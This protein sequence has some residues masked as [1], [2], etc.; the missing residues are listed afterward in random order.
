MIRRAFAQTAESVIVSWLPL[1][2]DMGLIGGVLQP[3]YLGARC[4]L[5]SPAAF[6]RRPRLWLEAIERYRATTSG[7][8]NFGYE[9]TADKVGEEER[10]GLDLASWQVAFNGAEPVRP[11]TLERFARAFAPCGFRSSAFY[12]C[13]GLAEATLLVSGGEAAAPPVVRRFSDAGLEAHRAETRAETR[14]EAA[15][16]DRR[17][18]GPA[19]PGR[20]RPA[21][22]GAARRDRRPRQPPP[23]AAGPGGRDLGRRSERRR[24]LLEPRRGDGAHLRSPPG[25]GR[26]GGGR[27]ALPAHRRPRLPRRRRRAVRHRPPQGPDHPARPQRLPAGRRAHRR[28][29][30]PGAAP[31]RR[32][33][34][35]RRR[36][37]RGTA[38]GGLRGRAPLPGRRPGRRR[39]GGRG[40]ARRRLRAA[41]GGGVRRRAAAG[42]RPAQDHQRQGAPRRVPPP[43]PVGGLPRPSR[44]DVDGAAG[45]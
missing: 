12:P 9:L 42:R 30:P 17:R 2:H 28:G 16:R 40:G 24:R 23:A 34:L 41:R 43:L 36:R 20:L 6:L 32:G 38:G 31:R 8:P 35:R 22:D 14:T 18:R 45:R 7:G 3:L 25:G 44:R 27:H 11:A 5:T 1:Y 21:V 15:P 10:A 13:Y 29:G 19:C 37:R 26:R 4:V 33:R 39:G